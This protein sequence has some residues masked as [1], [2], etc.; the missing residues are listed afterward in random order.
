MAIDPQGKTVLITGANR[1]IGLAFAEA[2]LAA[3]ISKL[4]ATARKPESVQPLIDKHGDKVVA[5]QLDISDDDSVKAA[6]AAATDVDIVVNNAGILL[7]GNYTSDEVF[8]NLD[9]E[10]EVNVK[11]L[12][13][14]ARAFA[15]VLKANGGGALAQLNS[16][17][18]LRNFADFTAY[19]ASKAA[20]YSITQGLHD[21][22][23][24]QGTDVV[25]V[26]PGPI[27]TDMIDGAG[28]DDIAPPPSVVAD[29]L[30]AALKAGEFH[31]F[32]DDFAKQFWAGYEGFG[33]GVVEPAMQEA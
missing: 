24:E 33:R 9:K 8:N 23:A 25:S 13:R 11:G 5:L 12:L 26:H 4:Y 6:A 21:M 20:S 19:C 2:F 7:H 18:S 17:A 3:G 1:G 31:C 30:I 15:P 27:K 14:M 22:L 29:A 16:V 32:P 10:I 28:F